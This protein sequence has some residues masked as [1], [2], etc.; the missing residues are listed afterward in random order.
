MSIQ[1][2]L[3]PDKIGVAL[4]S[5][6]SRSRAGFRTSNLRYGMKL[7]PDFQ[8]SFFIHL[9]NKLKGTTNYESYTTAT[10]ASIKS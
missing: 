6:R 8:D 5:R 2:A 10:T 7:L 4:N 1:V 3:N 9:V